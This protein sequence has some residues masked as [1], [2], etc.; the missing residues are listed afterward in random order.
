VRMLDRLVGCVRGYVDEDD[1]GRRARVV[2][3]QWIRYRNYM[4]KR[5]R[6]EVPRVVHGSSAEVE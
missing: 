6:G 1:G 3:E 5:A 2:L 4:S